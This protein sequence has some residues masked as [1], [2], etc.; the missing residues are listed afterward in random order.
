MTA[1]TRGHQLTGLASMARITMTLLPPHG[2][3]DSSKQASGTVGPGELVETV[4][5]LGTG[6]TALTGA[7]Q[8][9]VRKVTGAAASG[10][11]GLKHYGVAMRCVEFPGPAFEWDINN[12]PIEQVNSDIADGEYVR[13]GYSGQFLTTLVASGASGSMATT[14]TPGTKLTWNGAA[15]RSTGLT[16][17]GAWEA[18]TNMAVAIAEV[19][20][21]KPVGDGGLLEFKLL[22]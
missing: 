16:G 21:F 6:T 11:R 3:L 5:S 19:R 10:L 15:G 7:P 17:T 1:Y 22:T 20:S 14:Y 2:D 13:V 9:R 4:S 8:G 12:G 18:T